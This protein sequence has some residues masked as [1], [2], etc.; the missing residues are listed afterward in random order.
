MPT[1]VKWDH[2]YL[3]LVEVEDVAVAA[4]KSAEGLAMDVEVVEYNEGSRPHAHKSPGRVTFEDVTLSRG[5]TDDEDLYNW[6]VDCY[7]AVSGTGDVLPN[8]LKDVDIIQL[9]RDGSRKR[10]Y[11]LKDAFVKRLEYD[12]WDADT[13][14]TQME[15]VVIAYDHFTKEDL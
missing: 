2:K 15:S 5:V 1:P 3:F 6:A 9:D 10:R 14:E 7:N 4:F 13:N 12:S 11:S 8:L